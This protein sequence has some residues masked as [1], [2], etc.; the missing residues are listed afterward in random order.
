MR[1]TNINTNTG[2]TKIAYI[3][4]NRSHIM[5]MKMLTISPAFMILNRSI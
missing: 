3:R 4:A 2:G 5:C 1:V